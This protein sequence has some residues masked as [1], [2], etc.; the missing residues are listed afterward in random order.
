MVVGR[1]VLERWAA[2]NGGNA[3]SRSNSCAVPSE[4]PLRAHTEGDDHQVF[5]PFQVQQQA[6]LR[7]HP[8]V[9]PD[10]FRVFGT[11]PLC[12]GSEAGERGR[13]SSA[14]GGADEFPV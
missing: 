11:I 1:K 7:R 5:V 3:T 4:K 10:G 12:F 13:K 8:S 14:A 9:R 2:T 6:I